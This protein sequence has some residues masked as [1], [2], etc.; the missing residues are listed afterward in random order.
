MAQRL[1]QTPIDEQRLR[2]H[3]HFADHLHGQRARDVPGELDVA[4]RGRGDIARWI[5]P[6]ANSRRSCTASTSTTRTC[7]S[8]KTC[9]ISSRVRSASR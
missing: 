5:G 9:G 6:H 3:W 2:V 4:L 7:A 1:L 8:P